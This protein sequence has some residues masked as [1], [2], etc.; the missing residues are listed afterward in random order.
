MTIY[1]KD[2]YF[3]TS[4][5]NYFTHN[6]SIN[7]IIATKHFQNAKGNIYYISPICIY[8]ILLTKDELAK[9]KLIY[10]S[11]NLFH[12]K[13][14]K[15]PSEFIVNFVKGGI[16][17]IE[18][19]YDIHTELKIGEIWEE[20]CLN[21]NK[22]I[23]VDE[24][25]LHSKAEIL[26]KL[27]KNLYNIINRLTLDITIKDEIFYNQEMINFNF[28]L[29][30]EEYG[31]FDEIDK[32]IVKISILFVNYIFCIGVDLDPEPYIKFWD[33]LGIKSPLDRVLF[34]F[35]NYKNIFIVG[36]F[37]LMA[38]MAYSQISNGQK[39]NRGLILDCLH[40]VYLT[41]VDVFVTNDS[42]FDKFSDSVDIHGKKIMYLEKNIIT[43]HQVKIIN[44]K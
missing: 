27:S 22:S 12:N 14:I 19:P 16:P 9:E 3:E 18:I 15:S 8:E 41:Y 39:S 36:P 11:Q 5:I 37:Y 43:S 23:H 33:N 17:S 25:Y 10:C 30:N 21:K 32:K 35:K 38:T 31:P 20:I 13:L 4:A 26:R 6:F 2:F 24:K 7:D 42:H 1:N 40:S 34:L 44:E 29:L 28:N